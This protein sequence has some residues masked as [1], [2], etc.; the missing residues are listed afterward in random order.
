MAFYIH[1][2]DRDNVGIPMIDKEH[3]KMVSLI[4][5]LHLMREKDRDPDGIGAVADTLLQFAVI[6]F[7]NEELELSRAGCTGMSS[8][9]ADHTRLVEDL[10]RICREYEVGRDAD[11]LLR[12]VRAWWA[13]HINAD[14]AAF[15]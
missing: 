5:A 12:L 14:F 13:E 6:H 11:E 9:H 4:N 15:Q 7:R 8:I 1:W 3:Q 2:R 10:E